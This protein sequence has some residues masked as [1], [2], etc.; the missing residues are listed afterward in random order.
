MK[1]QSSILPNQSHT[2]NVGSDM[3]QDFGIPVTETCRVCRRGK[4]RPGDAHPKPEAAGTPSPEGR[5]RGG[6]GKVPMQLNM[7][8]G[9]FSPGRLLLSLLL[10][11]GRSF[12]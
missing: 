2:H 6:Q 5:G 9:L 10:G 7:N 4:E 11:P 12:R 8:G 3:R 1:Q